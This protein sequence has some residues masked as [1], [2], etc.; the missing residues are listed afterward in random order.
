MLATNRKEF[1]TVCLVVLFSS[2]LD[3][4]G[5]SLILVL[6]HSHLS[7]IDTQF[8]TRRLQARLIRG[9]GL[10]RSSSNNKLVLKNSTSFCFMLFW[11]KNSLF[12]VHPSP[13]DGESRLNPVVTHRDLSLPLTRGLLP[14]VTFI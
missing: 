9:C 5:S 14:R 12:F 8:P 4:K 13:G 1:E 11:E 10:M 6:S 7:I 2:I 3:T